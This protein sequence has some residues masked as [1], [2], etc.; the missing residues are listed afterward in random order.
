[1]YD[2]RIENLINAALADGQ[3]TEKEKQILFKNAEAQGIDLDE[4]EMILDARIVELKKA[5]AAQI[6]EHELEIAKTKAAIQSAQPSA[7]KS[8][9]FG[10]V[11]KCPA[12]GAMIQSF[13]AKCPECGMEFSNIKANSSVER[14][15][16]MLNE[17]EKKEGDSAFK[18]FWSQFNSNMTVAG[19]RKSEIISS[20][21]IPNTKEDIMEFIVFIAPKAKKVGLFSGEI[22]NPDEYRLIPVW[23]KK[24]Q[25]VFLKASISLKN[26]S[27]VMTLINTL[28][29]ELK[30][31]I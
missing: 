22:G 14:L 17:A 6:R 31:K 25:E 30:I 2:E 1:M 19:R 28:S 16:K 20:F 21:P 10:D 15:S 13:M 11:R 7:P 26:D 24:L 8:D 12:C 3:L 18:D 9:K 27:E 4:F 29:K 23:R 5:E